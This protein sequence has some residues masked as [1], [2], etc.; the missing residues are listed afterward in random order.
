M[1]YLLNEE[2]YINQNVF[3]FEE[4]INSQIGRFIDKSPSYVTYYHINSNSSSVDLGFENVDKTLGDNSPIRFNKINSFPIY[5][6][7][8]IVVSL[9]MDDTGLD[10]SYDGGEGIILPNTIIPMPNDYFTINYLD[11]I[12]TFMV[13]DIQYDTIRS[14]N[15]YKVVFSLKSVS[16]DAYDKLEKQ[17]VESYTCFVENIGTEE[18][19]II[20]DDVAVRLQDMSKA[21]RYLAEEY[22]NLFYNK[23]YNVLLF[24][25]ENGTKLYDAYQTQFINT[26]SLLHDGHDYK[27]VR[28]SEE[29]SHP[30]MKARYRKSIYG[31]LENQDKHLLNDF[32]FWTNYL[33]NDES[34][35][36]FYNER[37][38]R[39]VHFLLE[40]E[41]QEQGYPYLREGL[42]ERIMHPPKPIK[43]NQIAIV[44]PKE[45]EVV[46]DEESVK[47][48]TPP[49]LTPELECLDLHHDLHLKEEIPLPISKKDSEGNIVFDP[50][51][52]V[53]EED[54]PDFTMIKDAQANLNQETPRSSVNSTNLEEPIVPKETILLQDIVNTP[55]DEY[56]YFDVMDEYLIRFFK[57]DTITPYEM[58]IDDIMEL[59]R[60]LDYELETF[61][62]IPILLYVLKF[63]YKKMTLL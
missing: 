5:G 21:Y 63:Y 16:G 28:L 33:N 9:D 14:N 11:R 57:K 35:F 7:D 25:M 20:R 58:K 49:E 23:K 15:F 19:A 53:D 37:N 17:T 61:I 32:H 41:I 55:E 56:N 60:S 36:N 38:L 3:L 47:P 31:A 4:R 44:P 18:H 62:N 2:K 24:E 50:S 48:T 42:Y 13:T 46:G 43:P 52:Y 39:V 27:V 10:G 8:Q 59:A 45:V 1:G 54:V 30:R 22:Y 6:I 34:I 12:F 26:H 29:D 40:K 51:T